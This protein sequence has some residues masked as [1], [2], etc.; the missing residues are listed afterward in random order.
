M[1]HTNTSSSHVQQ[2]IEAME[3]VAS[4]WQQ[5]M[6]TQMGDIDAV[7]G[8]VDAFMKANMAKT[9]GHLDEVSK[10]TKSAVQWATELQMNAWNSALQMARTASESFQKARN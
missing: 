6:K 7:I 1:D 10:L 9:E 3:R 2:G 5:V 4:F 8:K